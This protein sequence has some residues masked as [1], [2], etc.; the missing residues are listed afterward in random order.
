[1]DLLVFHRF[2]TYLSYF[3]CIS[4]V[5]LA[6][7]R[8]HSY[9]TDFSVTTRI[10]TVPVGTTTDATTYIHITTGGQPRTTQPN[11][12]STQ[13]SELTTPPVVATHTTRTVQRQQWT[14][15]VPALE[16]S[17]NLGTDTT[18]NIPT[19]TDGDDSHDEIPARTKGN[20]FLYKDAM[21]RE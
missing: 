9:F 13:K 17:S 8:F 2:Y 11:T 21:A 14:T 1:M 19:S 3:T 16:S 4:H 6:S 20:N 10:P 7:H 15:T 5:S 18:I 12:I